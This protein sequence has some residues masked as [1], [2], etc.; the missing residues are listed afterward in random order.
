[1]RKKFNRRRK[2]LNNDKDGF[3]PGVQESR[4]WMKIFG[5]TSSINV[6]QEIIYEKRR[7]LLREYY[8]NRVI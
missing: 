2:K 8:V 6:S 3:Q 7:A 4:D 1:V 5:T